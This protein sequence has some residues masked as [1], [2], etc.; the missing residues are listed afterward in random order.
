MLISHKY[1][2]ELED[3]RNKLKKPDVRNIVNALKSAT[4]FLVTGYL[5]LMLAPLQ[6]HKIYRIWVCR[7]M[8]SGR[9]I[10]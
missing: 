5:K 6:Q 1:S 4:T 10:Y 3:N 7:M 8:Y 2:P 9:C